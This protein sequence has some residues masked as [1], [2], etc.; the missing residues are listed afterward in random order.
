[1]F[2]FPFCCHKRKDDAQCGGKLLE[3]ISSLD[4][5]EKSERRRSCDASSSLHCAHLT[6]MMYI[7]DQPSALGF[8]AISRLVPNIVHF[9]G[10]MYFGL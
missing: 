4:F 1:M 2:V 10:S 3:L 7:R 9:I 8:V 6:V 5:G